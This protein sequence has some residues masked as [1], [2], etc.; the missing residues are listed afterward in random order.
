MS[1]MISR[2]E[3]ESFLSD[4]L[5]DVPTIRSETL[6]EDMPHSRVPMKAAPKWVNQGLSIIYVQQVCSHCGHIH[7]H[8]NPLLLMNTAYVAADGTVLKT[9]KTAYP[10]TMEEIENLSER[11]SI[12]YLEGE[13][14]PFCE[15]CLNEMQWDDFKRL[16]RQQQERWQVKRV[17]IRLEREN[18]ISK[19]AAEAALKEKKAAKKEI[20]PEVAALFAS[21]EDND[22][23]EIETIAQ[24][25][26]EENNG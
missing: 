2:A 10:K 1:T 13:D 23:K 24:S 17:G 5:S 12:E 26:E 16:F 7:V 25:D 18:A 3:A 19:A 8:S 21:I 14:I 4:L 15:E 9:E 6:F 22:L 20:S 11:I